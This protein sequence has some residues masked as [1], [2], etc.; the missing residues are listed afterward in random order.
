M[1]LILIA[2]ISLTASISLADREARCKKCD[3]V[4]VACLN[5]AADNADSV[6]CE[7]NASRCKQASHCEKNPVL[8]QLEQETDTDRD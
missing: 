6:K 8:Q 7:S 5:Q 1:K 3:S 4:K 2:L